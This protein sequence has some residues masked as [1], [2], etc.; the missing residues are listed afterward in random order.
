MLD[1]FSV[2]LV[3]RILFWFWF[4]VLERILSRVDLL[5]LFFFSRVWVLLGWILSW[6]F[7]SVCMLGKDFD[8]FLVV[9]RIMFIFYFLV[10]LS[11]F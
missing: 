3:N 1:L 11:V 7:E 2:L 10:V 5:V 8:I 4:W 6:V 9:S